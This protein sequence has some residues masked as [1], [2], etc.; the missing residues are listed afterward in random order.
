MLKVTKPGVYDYVLALATVAILTALSA[1]F[2]YGTLESWNNS[3]NNPNWTRGPLYADYLGRMNAYAYPFVVALVLAL[4]MCI[5]KRFI[6]RTY[7]LQSSFVILALSAMVGIL[8]GFAW[9]LGFLLLISALLQLVVVVL[10]GARTGT[11]VFEREGA[12]VQI[13]SALLHLGFVVFVFDLVLVADIRRHLG[14]FWFST[15]LITVG[16]LMSFYPRE[17]ASLVR[18]SKQG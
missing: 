9:G 4:C 3:I 10:T 6:P 15:A 7:L 18:R 16:T 2:I 14:I 8:W 5:P 12:L 17:I 1:V 11:L 13:G